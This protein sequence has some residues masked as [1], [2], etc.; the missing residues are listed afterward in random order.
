MLRLMPHL[1]VTGGSGSRRQDDDRP[2]LNAPVSAGVWVLAVA[3]ALVLAGL[4][5][6]EAGQATSSGDAPPLTPGAVALIASNLTPD[7]LQ[8]LRAALTHDDPVVRALAARAAAVVRLRT[9]A[10]A[11]TVALE[12]EDVPPVA[13]EQI[14][15]LLRVDPAGRRD[16]VERHLARGG[17]SAAGVYLEWVRRQ[18]PGTLPEH[19]D[20]L[21]RA[22]AREEVTRL[23]PA[24]FAAVEQLDPELRPRV[25]RSWLAVSA[26][27]PA[28][29]VAHPWRSALAALPP[30]VL[31]TE[32]AII[33]EALASSD[34]DIRRETVWWTVEI[35]AS[36]DS[37]PE[38][39]LTAVRTPARASESADTSNDWESFGRELVA[40]HA[41]APPVD[42]AGIVTRHGN[43]HRADAESAV[44]LGVL[45]PGEQRALRDALGGKAVDAVQNR[46]TDTRAKP[47]G[48]AIPD[49]FM[50]PRVLETLLASVDCRV[51]RT[52]RLGAVG[53]EVAADGSIAR[54]F[55]DHGSLAEQCRQALTALAHLALPER[56]FGDRIGISWLLLP[57]FDEYVACVNEAAADAWRTAS[58]P[59]SR[60]AAAR[61]AD[62]VVRPVKTRHVNPDYPSLAQ[63][64]GI[65][66][67]VVVESTISRTG[68][69][70]TA[71]VT[72]SVHRALDAAAVAA[73][74]R[75]R[76][77]PSRIGADPVP[78]IMTVTVNFTL[79]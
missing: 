22:L 7:N 15:A 16:S 68:C 46:A 32:A 61:H 65:Q 28:V 25:L 20:R 29:G 59:S 50:W 66:G 30:A 45:T 69:V 12:R 18:D 31:P 10:E 43:R 17:P 27:N 26:E 62:A 58:T 9:A 4:V 21:G 35:L 64:D 52:P 53:I 55:V 39:V 14:R 37:A 33:S 2:M 13:V 41:G 77:L 42:R 3:A 75:W 76:F 36:G 73:I 11:L 74:L 48:L 34:S 78:V 19:I 38:P 57:V 54:L 67:V 8:R 71:R 51:T 44:L 72:G 6:I 49:V 79:P 40:R 60:G 56:G 23:V 5:T 70:A 63:R 1:T 24:L 47:P